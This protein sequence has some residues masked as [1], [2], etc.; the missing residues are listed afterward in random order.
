MAYDLSLT[1]TKCCG[2][3]EISGLRGYQNDPKGATASFCKQTLDQRARFGMSTG[4]P[5]ELYPMY[6]FSAAVSDG[7]NGTYLENYGSQWA[8]YIEGLALGT[9]TASPIIRNNAFHPDHSNQVWI[10]APDRDALVK[11][12]KA[13]KEEAQEEAIRVAKE[14][15]AAVAAIPK[16]PAPVVGPKL[17]Q[18]I[19]FG[20]QVFYGGARG[21]GKAE[22]FQAVAYA[23][24]E[25]VYYL[26][27][28]NYVMQQGRNFLVDVPLPKAFGLVDA[29]VPDMKVDFVD[30][31]DNWDVDVDPGDED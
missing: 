29:D 1:T 11:W 31:N 27:Q 14:Q 17:A 9:I 21:A 13:F 15:Q 22:A 24:N 18:E 3:Q 10:W 30:D 8:A 25:Y 4:Q 12:Y 6:I 20:E 5:G 7:P 28:Q 2:M 19:A 23:P 16:D 26:N